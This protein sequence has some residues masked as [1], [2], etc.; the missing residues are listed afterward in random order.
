VYTLQVRVLARDNGSPARSATAVVT[1]DI[2]RNFQAPIWVDTS[3]SVTIPEVL[4]YGVTFT[5]VQANDFDS[6]VMKTT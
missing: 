2:Q 6:Q 1:V 3:K 5:N 4:A